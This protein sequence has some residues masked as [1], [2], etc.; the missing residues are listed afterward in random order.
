M[1]KPPEKKKYH[2]CSRMRERLEQ[3][4]R[5][6]ELVEFIKDAEKRGEQVNKTHAENL[7]RN[8][9]IEVKPMVMPPLGKIWFMN[10]LEHEVTEDMVCRG[11]KKIIIPKGGLSSS[12][13]HT[14]HYLTKIS[15][16]SGNTVWNGKLAYSCH[17]CEPPKPRKRGLGRHGWTCKRGG[18]ST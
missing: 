6:Q 15:E 3:M 16:T 17:D 5:R 10:S 12:A 13:P 14:Q 18:G 4:L 9:L 2:H 11:C 1:T 7:I 8:E